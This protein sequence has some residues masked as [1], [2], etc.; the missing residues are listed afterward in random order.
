[1]VHYVYILR[2]SDNS[3]YIGQTNN[4]QRRIKQHNGEVTG[5]AKYTLGRRPVILVYSE[6]HASHSEAF[7]RERLLKK[8]NRKQK[9]KLVD[10]HPS[11]FCAISS[12]KASI[13]LPV[14]AEIKIGE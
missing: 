14:L 12:F 1:M 6:T 7:T 8:L 5:G 2:C 10:T 11:K 13:P 4:L 9:E 3:F